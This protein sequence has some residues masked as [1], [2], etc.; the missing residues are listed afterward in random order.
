MTTSPQLAFA[1][2][3]IQTQANQGLANTSNHVDM[4]FAFH[5]KSMWPD[6]CFQVY[7]FEDI[8]SFIGN[9]S[10]KQN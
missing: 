8:Y 5:Q 7:S 10:A 1:I 3:A 2:T 9:V 4:L 6:L